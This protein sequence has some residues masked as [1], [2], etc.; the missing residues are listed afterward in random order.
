V[1]AAV[2]G[3]LDV[4]NKIRAYGAKTQIIG[5]PQQDPDGMLRY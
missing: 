4:E 5:A 3:F 1:L 2:Y